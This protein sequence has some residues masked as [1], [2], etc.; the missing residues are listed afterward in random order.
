MRKKSSVNDIQK[1]NKVEL[2]PKNPNQRKYLELLEKETQIIALGPAGTGK[3]FLASAVAARK[4]LH[5]KISKIIVT[6]P[7]V[8]VDEEW[9]A[10]PGSLQKKTAPWAYPVLEIVEEFMGKARFLEAQRMGD[11]EVLPLAFMRGRTLQNS[12]CILDE[13]QNTTIN[14]MKMFVTRIGENSTVLINGD[15]AQTDVRNGSGLAWLLYMSKKYSNLP[16]KLLEFTEN[17]VTRSAACAAWV[18]AINKEEKDFA[19]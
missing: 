14:Q 18:K 15:I 1:A 6:R 7:R 10:L 3:T 8:E 13:A 9:G 11:I 19:S 17:D 16:A 12:F 4:Y 5:G 2:S